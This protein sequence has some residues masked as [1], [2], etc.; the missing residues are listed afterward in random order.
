MI[1]FAFFAS[2]IHGQPYGRPNQALLNDQ[3]GLHAASK[4]AII[5]AAQDVLQVKILHS[6][7]GEAIIPQAGIA[8]NETGREYSISLST[9][10]PRE[11]AWPITLELTSKDGTKFTATT[12][13]N[14]LAIP[15]ASQSMT[16]ID[17]LRGGLQV[18][19]YSPEWEPF[20]PYSFYLGGPWLE[21]SPD[22]MKK[23]KEFGYNVLHIIPGAEGIG[24]D[25]DQL[26][27]WFDEAEQLG[28]WIMFDMRWTYKNNQYVKIQVERYRSRKNMLLWYTG[29]EMDG[30]E[31]PPDAPGNIYPFIKSLDPYHPISLCLNCQNY[32]FQEYTAGT[33]IIMTTTYPIGTNVE[34]S[35]ISPTTPALS[36][37]PSRM[38]LYARFQQ[39]F[40]LVP[41]PI[42]SVPQAFTEQLFWTR[43][44]TP[45]EVIA[46]IMLS[47]NHGTTGIVMWS[48][49]TADPIMEVTSK[50]SALVTSTEIVKI[51][52][53][54]IR[55]AVGVD[56]NGKGF[57]DA[58]AWRFYD[59]MMVSV[60]NMS[61]EPVA[62]LIKIDLPDDVRVESVGR[63][64]WGGGSWKAQGL[65]TLEKN[66]MGAVESSVFM[67]VLD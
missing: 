14:Y 60:V 15:E 29:D 54:G 19:S 56:G 27:K 42:W 65:R 26:D 51:L 64:L 39:Q 30:R 63:M 7:S 40:G 37:I 41:K 11:T 18:R 46:M 12:Q 21:S 61:D 43:A 44:P 6:D 10:Q 35:T 20:F 50:F 47:I 25:L 13:L 8:F 55:E 58:R 34:Y 59:R 52:L 38:D 28:L 16:R 49:P 1:L 67:V 17:S 22:N 2:Y 45:E 24:Y 5:D 4:S 48:W 53:K 57:L 31:D 9:F 32:F 23:F 33:D 36:N 66:G 3:N 62:G